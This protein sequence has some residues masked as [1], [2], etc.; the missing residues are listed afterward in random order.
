[1]KLVREKRKAYVMAGHGEINDP[2]LGAARSARARRRSAAPRCSRSGSASSTTRSRTSGSSISSKDVP[3]DATIVF[4]LAPTVPLQPAEWEALDRYLDRGGRLL[5]ALD[6]S[7]EPSLGPLE[8][9]LGSR[10]RRAT[11]P[12]TRRSCRSAARCRIA[13]S[14]ITTQFSAHASTT[15][16]SRS[17]DKGL[18]L[19]EAGALEDAP[20]TAKGERA[21]EDRDA[22]L[23][24]DRASSTYNHDRQLHVR[25]RDEKKQRWNIGAAVEG[26]KVGGKDGFRALVFADVAAVRRCAI[27]RAAWARRDDPAS[28]VRLLDDVVQ[29]ARRRGGVRRRRRVRRRQADQAHEGSGRGVV[30]ADHVGAPLL[31]FTL[32]LVG[33]W[34]R[35][36]RAKKPEV[37]P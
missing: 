22:A 24:G 26:P 20:F 29:L 34:A 10:C 1:M 27:V 4:L 23:D 6:P 18:V 16:L 9:K 19:I 12:M 8:G 17:V 2:G 36:R 33:T 13:G 3:D 15:S 37:K 25:R 30:H 28:R 5:V 14:S 31:V 21:E 7:A 11:S 35:K 32:G